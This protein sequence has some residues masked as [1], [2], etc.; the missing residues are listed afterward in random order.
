ME[1]SLPPEGPTLAVLDWW[2]DRFHADRQRYENADSAAREPVEA[3]M[4][5][6]EN[7]GR[8]SQHLANI[9]AVG[10]ESPLRAQHALDNAHKAAVRLLALVAERFGID[11]G[12]LLD[13]GSLCRSLRGIPLTS[14]PPEELRRG[15]LTFQRL[16]VL[17]D[18]PS[19]SADGP[20]RNGKPHRPRRKG[21]PRETKTLTARQLE[22]VKVVGEC[23]G[24]FAEAARRMGIDRKTCRQHYD[25]AMRKLG[26]AAPHAKRRTQSLPTDRRGGVILAA[27]DD[28]RQ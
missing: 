3:A 26:R 19:T 20:G 21:T 2:T 13:A 12:P 17:W 27:G 11:S 7:Y 25:S 18:A 28:C 14:G 5:C 8:L 24:Y 10:N 4:G 9:A 15:E 1:V 6:W 16:C 22:A 23:D